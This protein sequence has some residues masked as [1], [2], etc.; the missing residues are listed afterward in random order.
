IRCDAIV[1]ECGQP[2]RLNIVT[3]VA[4][5][6]CS[7]SAASRSGVID[8]VTPANYSGMRQLIGKSKSWRD[9]AVIRVVVMPTLPVEE[10]FDSVQAAESLQ[11]RPGKPVA[12]CHS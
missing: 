7:S 11:L 4:P 1:V 5:R 6:A 8:A 2:G 3:V 10:Y 9:I 12:R